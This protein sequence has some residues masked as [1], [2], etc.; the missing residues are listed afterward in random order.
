MNA[1]LIT[2]P[3]ALVLGLV[4][5]GVFIYAFKKGQFEDIEGPKHRMFFDDDER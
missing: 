1:L 5:L 4:A 3:I 2:I